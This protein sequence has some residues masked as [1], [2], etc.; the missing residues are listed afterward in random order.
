MSESEM[1]DLFGVFKKGQAR[2]A[3]GLTWIESNRNNDEQNLHW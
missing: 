3:A 1:V 2:F